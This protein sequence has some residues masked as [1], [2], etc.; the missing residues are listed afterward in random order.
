MKNADLFLLPSFHEAA[1]M[2]VDEARCL[3]LPVL[4]TETTSARD[5]IVNTHSG[6]VCKNNQGAISDA[7][8][9]L[10]NQKEVVYGKKQELQCHTIDNNGAILNFKKM[11]GDEIDE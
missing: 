11:L 4:S 3:G 5:M 10:L 6:W 2:V 8:F 9:G 1:P 7:L